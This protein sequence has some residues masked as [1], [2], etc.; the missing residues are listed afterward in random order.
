MKN[1]KTHLSK[2]NKS[3][4]KKVIKTYIKADSLRWGE[5][6][7]YGCYLTVKKFFQLDEINYQA[8][9]NYLKLN[10]PDFNIFIGEVRTTY[11]NQKNRAE[12][13]IQLLFDQ[14]WDRVSGNRCYQTQKYTHTEET[15]NIKI[16]TD[17]YKL[18]SGRN[19]YITTIPK[20]QS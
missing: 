5:S 12:V 9:V 3:E 10:L 4:F 15:K 8:F 11:S 19:L 1:I 16:S 17:K 14:T 7:T 6:Y 13:S 20:K 2:Y 18:K